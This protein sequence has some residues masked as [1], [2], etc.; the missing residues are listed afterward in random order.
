MVR[1]SALVVLAVLL[2]AGCAPPA[3]TAGPTGLTALTPDQRIELLRVVTPVEWPRRSDRT[4][5]LKI[6][7]STGTEG[8][9]HLATDGKQTP[10]VELTFQICDRRPATEASALLKADTPARLAYEVVDFYGRKVAGGNLG[11]VVVPQGG[12]AECKA[13][14]T[15]LTQAGYYEA[16]AHLTWGDKSNK[17]ELTARQGFALIAPPRPGRDT[18][19]RIGCASPQTSA[20]AA[21]C[22]TLYVDQWL[23]GGA[24]VTNWN[25]RAADRPWTPKFDPAALEARLELFEKMGFTVVGRVGQPPE[26]WRGAVG[27][28]RISARGLPADA[29]EYAGFTAPLVKSFPSI[30]R[31]DIL[32][33]P[34][35]ELGASAAALDGYLATES[36]AIAKVRPDA[37]L[38]GAGGPRAFNDYLSAGPSR[39]LLGGLRFV[40]PSVDANLDRWVAER[41]GAKQWTA[42]LPPEAAEIS[43][44]RRAW[45][46]VRR[47]VSVLAAGGNLDLPA[48][49]TLDPACCA[50]LAPLAAMLDQ[51]RAETAVWPHL[52]LVKSPV[53]A[54]RDR[55]VAVLWT[56]PPGDAADGPAERGLLTIP[57]ATTLETFDCQGQPIGLWRG[58]S[59]LLP[60]GEAPIYITSR[61]LS[62][63]ALAAKIAPAAMQSFTPLAV[64]AEP[65]NEAVDSQATVT[66]ELV[67]LIPSGSDVTVETVGPEGWTAADA[68]QKVHVDPGHPARLAVRFS[69]AAR[70]IENSYPFTVRLTTA[71]WKGERVLVAQEAVVAARRSPIAID[72][73]LDS[74]S[75]IAPLVV[76]LP[77]LQ[78]EPAPAA[79]VKSN[80]RT[81]GG[82]QA[83]LRMSYDAKYLYVAAE[84]EQP[85][86]LNRVR[87]IEPTGT[88]AGNPWGVGSIQ[89]ALA[90]AEAAQPAYVLALAPTARRPVVVLLHAPG[91][92][93]RNPLPDRPIAGWG[94]VAGSSA[95]I[96][97][98]GAS[99]AG[100]HRVVYEAAIPRA[101]LTALPWSAGDR[102]NFSFL[103]QPA[104]GVEADWSTAAGV[105]PW[106]SSA[107]TFFPIGIERRAAMG[108]V[109]L[110]K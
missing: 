22:K 77:M 31:W 86:P 101:A 75:N 83:T 14:L 38:W 72:G 48:T 85:A 92:D 44:Q 35:D 13:A 105:F 2:A 12:A 10:P 24:G 63:A 8:E 107:T 26:A 91:M 110:G 79:V 49:T 66:L 59:L 47:A 90:P 21:G 25:E 104:D 30:T 58:R 42:T 46:L 52:P 76:R 39:G 106:Q 6:A 87:T 43:P 7:I 23:A 73:N 56:E 55:A 80:E 9:V 32:P 68:P 89:L 81:E 19:G 51:S 27:S 16:V 34:L 100:R 74:W 97:D 29:V 61:V 4:G 70:R 54:A 60:L 5:P 33:D 94:E 45:A 15:G 37:A 65:I 99:A 82:P 11:D 28:D 50:V 95:A 96:V 3:P 64:R 53:F 1:A 103:V 17:S 62:A 78:T 93:L 41:A 71:D 36:A 98:A 109:G 88:S 84:V 20:A 57:D 102:W 67:A 108:S 18:V 40:G 69:K